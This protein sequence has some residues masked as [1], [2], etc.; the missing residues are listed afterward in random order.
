ML[1]NVFSLF[2]TYTNCLNCHL[3][4]CWPCIP[5]SD[6]L[7]LLTGLNYFP[8]VH[9][10][11]LLTG[12]NCFPRVCFNDFAHWHELFSSG[13]LTI[14][15]CQLKYF[16]EEIKLFFLQRSNSQD[17]SVNMC[18]ADS[19]PK[20]FNTEFVLLNSRSFNCFLDAFAHFHMKLFCSGTYT[21]LGLEN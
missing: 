7:I 11:Y 9:F 1:P 15:I 14:F 10:N 17:P 13:F 3:P 16:A 18:S 6:S 19:T 5:E 21:E 12:L 4:I 8:R 2:T 20:S